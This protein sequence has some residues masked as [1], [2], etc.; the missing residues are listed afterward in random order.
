MSVKGRPKQAV[1]KDKRF[2]IRLSEDTYNTLNKCAE[3]LHISK[4]EVIHKGIAL[5]EEELNKK[6]P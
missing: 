6:T 1:T 4:A 5:V 2:E 3:Q